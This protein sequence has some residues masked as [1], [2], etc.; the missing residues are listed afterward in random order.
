MFRRLCVLALVAG[1]AV[2]TVSAQLGV[3]TAAPV[4]PGSPEAHAVESVRATMRLDFGAVAHLTDSRALRELRALWTETARQR[5]PSLRLLARMLTDG[6]DSVVPSLSDSAFF[7]R[8]MQAGSLRTQAQQQVADARVEV[9]GH[10]VEAPD[11]AY[12]VYRITRPLTGTD[13]VQHKVLSLRRVDGRWFSMIEGDIAG[14][15]E[16]LRGKP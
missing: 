9:L 4:E 10:V 14:A 1:V 16:R 2:R 5:D 12:V 3:T 7:V 15:L 11:R 13:A 6:R 8:S